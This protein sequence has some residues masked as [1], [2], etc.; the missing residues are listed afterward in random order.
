MLPA[1]APPRVLGRTGRARARKREAM[2]SRTV[3]RSHAAPGGAAGALTGSASPSG[4]I[5]AE[6]TAAASAASRQEEAGALIDPFERDLRF[7]MR[8]LTVAAEH[9]ILLAREVASRLHEGEVPDAMLV[10]ERMDLAQRHV[11]EGADDFMDTAAVMAAN[12][13]GTQ[14]DIDWRRA[15]RAPSWLEHS[16]QTR[17]AAASAYAPP[18]ANRVGRPLWTPVT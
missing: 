1:W 11:R 2:Q 18:T 14:Q 10:I 12:L 9:L 7:R 3:R 16:N 8:A 5:G 6:A 13:A 15:R 4:A 17:A